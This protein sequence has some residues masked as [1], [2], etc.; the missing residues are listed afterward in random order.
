MDY[1]AIEQR[2]ARSSGLAQIAQGHLGIRVFALEIFACF[3]RA[4]HVVIGTPGCWPALSLSGRF[5]ISQW[6]DFGGVLRLTHELDQVAARCILKGALVD[7]GTDAILAAK[8][9]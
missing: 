1:L 2:I 9:S 4:L 5:R 7:P 6:P 8:L 3:D